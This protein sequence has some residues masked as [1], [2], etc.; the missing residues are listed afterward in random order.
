MTHD[1]RL[2]HIAGNFQN[3]RLVPDPGK[4]SRTAKTTSIAISGR[5]WGGGSLVEAT[6]QIAE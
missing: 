1:T 5:L 4:C 6:L 2:R 3:S